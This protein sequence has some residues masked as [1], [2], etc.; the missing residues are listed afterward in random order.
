[1]SDLT[2][3]YLLV[4]NPNSSVSPSQGQPVSNVTAYYHPAVEGETEVDQV[5]ARVSGSYGLNCQLIGLDER[6][7]IKRRL[8]ATLQEDEA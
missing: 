3:I 8:T 7:A 2:G 5:M 6:Y 1:M 4:T